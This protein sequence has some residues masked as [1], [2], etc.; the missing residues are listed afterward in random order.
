MLAALSMPWGVASDGTL[1]YPQSFVIPIFSD[2][3]PQLAG[4]VA[5]NLVSAAA[6]FSLLL[7]GVNYFLKFINYLARSVG[8]AFTVLLMPAIILMV[9]VLIGIDAA[10][11]AF[12]VLDP[13]ANVPAWPWQP[14]FTLNGAHDELGYYVW[15]IGTIL[16]FVGGLS[17]PF[18]R[19]VS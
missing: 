6:A 2:N 3:T 12:G 9:I 1:V 10:A 18:V 7:V 14:G 8:C 13:V 19:R 4:Q 17:Q 5:Q 15:Y 16:N 11:L